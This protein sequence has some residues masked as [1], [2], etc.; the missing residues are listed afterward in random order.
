MA[1]VNISLITDYDAGVIEGT[2]AV[3]ALS[4]LE[5]FELN[6][7]RIRKVVLDMIGRVPGRPRRARR[8][9]GAAL[10]PGRRPRRVGRGHPPVRDEPVGGRALPIGVC[11]RTIRAEP[12][13]WLESAQAP[14]RGRLCRAS[15]PGTTSWAAA[16]RRS[17]SSSPGRSS[18]RPP[19]RRRGSPSAPFVHQRHEPA[20]GRPRPDG[21]HAP[22]RQRRPAHPGHRHRRPPGRARGARHPVPARPPERVARLEEAVAVLRALWTGGPVTRPSPFYPLDDA[23]ARPDPRSRR[24]ASSSAARRRAGARLAGRIGDGWSTFDDNFEANLPAYLEA[25]EASGRRRAD[26]LVH[27]RLPGRRLARRR[28]A[29]RHR[30]GP[31]PARDVGALEGGRRRRRDRHGEVD[32]GHRRARRRRRALVTRAAGRRGARP[33]CRAIRGTIDRA[34]D[35]R[36]PDPSPNRP[37]PASA[38]AGRSRCRWAMCDR[39]NPLGLADPAASQVHGTVFLGDRRRDRGLLA[40][41]G[42]ALRSAASGRSRRRSRARGRRRAGRP[43]R[44]PDR[45]EPRQPGGQLHLPDPRAAPRLESD[46]TAYFLSPQIDPGATVTFTRETAVAGLGRRGRPHR[47][48]HDPVTRRPDPAV[49]SAWAADLAFAIDIGGP[50]RRRPHGPLRAAGADPPQERQG[51]RDRGR[52]LSEELILAAIREHSPGDGML[53]EESGGHAA[54]SGAAATDKHGRV[55]VVDPLDGTVNYANGI[56]FFCVSIGLVVDGRPVVGVV[57]DPT[58]GETFAADGRRPGAARRHGEPRGPGHH[59]VREGQAVRLRRRRWR[60]AAGRCATR[61]RAV[62]KA[63]RVSRSMGAAALAL[64]YVGERPVRRVRPVERPVDLGH[65][66]GGAHRGAGR[67]DRHRHD[68]RPLVRPRPAE[69]PDRPVRGP[70]GAPRGAARPRPGLTG[71]RPPGRLAQ[72]VLPAMRPAR[73]RS[74]P[75]SSHSASQAARSAPAPAQLVERRLGQVGV[76]AQPGQRPVQLELLVAAPPGRRRARPLPG[77]RARPRRTPRPGC[78]RAS[79]SGRGRRPPTSSPSPGRPG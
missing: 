39:C 69:Q 26:Q 6:A 76:E 15:G 48:L 12:R 16:T 75:S 73:S 45:H 18:R 32:R 11:I 27:R 22:D 1:V 40:H 47:R 3:N 9:R 33:G 61:I 62:R 10:H 8:G 35:R 50:G 44:D 38:V 20:P 17:R 71:R 60:S 77:G 25:L 28:P 67:R 70:A 13:W 19:A 7:A 34:D 52:H 58:R 21:L 63:V 72:A 49:S 2:E 42:P 64:A 65:R 37:T 5:V 74:R 54:A 4:V 53:A 23:Y 24:R 36:R 57:H 66:G 55:W 68:R 56:P 79:R 29:R 43:E 78:R 31:R 30:L 14:R 59:R 46:A 41:R 51:R